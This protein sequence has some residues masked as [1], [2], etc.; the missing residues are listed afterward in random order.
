MY[1][2]ILVFKHISVYI[3]SLHRSCTWAHLFSFSITGDLCRRYQK[4]IDS[5]RKQVEKAMGKEMSAHQY[6]AN[7]VGLAEN[8][9]KERDSLKYLVSLL[10]VMF[11]EL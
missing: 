11:C 1:T 2:D 3:Y 9:T 8:V 6:L 5:L 7:L 10:K 4:K